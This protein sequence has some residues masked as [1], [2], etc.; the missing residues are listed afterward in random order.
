MIEQLPPGVLPSPE[1][2]RAAVVLSS[3]A[4]DACHF[5]LKPSRE[6]WVRR[7]GETIRV[8]ATHDDW[9]ANDSCAPVEGRRAPRGLDPATL[10]PFDLVA[11]VVEHPIYVGSVEDGIIR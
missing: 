6:T 2:I 10:M 5:C 4:G 8:C 7:N 9:L 11:R 3:P 1:P